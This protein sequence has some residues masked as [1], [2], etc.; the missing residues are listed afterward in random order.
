MRI[1]PL[2][3]CLLVAPS[4]ARGEPLDPAR[5][6]QEDFRKRVRAAG[7]KVWVDDKLVYEGTG[8]KADVSVC[9]FKGWKQVVIAVDGEER[10]RLP[11]R[12]LERP[13]AWPPVYMDE[14]KP[15]LTRITEDDG[16]KATLI[17][18]VT[19]T[20]GAEVE[21]YRGAALEPKTERTGQ[22]LLVRLGGDVL[23]RLAR[24][25]V[26]RLTPQE[27]LDHVNGFRE[28]AGLE[29][30]KL[31]PALSKGC[32]LHALY[33]VRNE[34]RGLA[35]H[36]ED[37]AGIGY[38]AEGARAG[39]R[40][41]LSQ[42]RVDETP[43]DAVDG[44]VATLYHR[45]GVL[46]PDLTEVGIGWA[47]RKDG[48][49]QF[50]M[51]VG[52]PGAR[53]EPKPYPIVYPANGQADVPLDFGLGAGEQPNP[54]PVAGAKAGYPVTIQFTAGGWKPSDV[55]AGLFAGGTE[56]VPVWLST[57]EKPARADRP[58]P[59]VVCLIPKQALRPASTYVVRLRCR[60]ADRAGRPS[61][62]GDWSF[63]TRR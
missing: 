25:P 28:R 12:S 48:M 2:L 27:V 13:V 32:D 52:S 38:T 20:G 62:S 5:G 46:D 29:K 4:P 51:D 10:A 47:Y 55:E 56:E 58:Q 21:I 60:M 33:V 39:A 6:G 49:G 34:S 40:S 1:A 41:V 44:L 22:G 31:N 45:L 26:P 59:W 7:A 57:P 8:S 50:V 24:R 14:I 19:T 11:V 54:V 61:F 9:D 15:H 23:Y 63:T 18:F 42:F 36:D 43:R 37:L 30:A 3:A 16:K 17:L 53:R 35:A